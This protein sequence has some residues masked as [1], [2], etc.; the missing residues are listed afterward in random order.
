MRDSAE[1]IVPPE[2]GQIREVFMG[3]DDPLALAAQALVKLRQ[4][5]LPTYIEPA[6]RPAEIEEYV[7]AHEEPSGAE[8]VV[9][10]HAYRR[11]R[12][13]SGQP[14]Q[15]TET[16][17]ADTRSRVA[18]RMGKSVRPSAKFLV[19]R[20]A[21]GA[22]IPD[23]RV[24]VLQSDTAEIA[25]KHAAFD[26]IFNEYSPR[27]IRFAKEIVDSEAIAQ[28][29]VQEAFTAAWRNINRFECRDE[30][31]LKNWLYTITRNASLN[32][33]RA[34]SSSQ[35]SIDHENWE[36]VS[37]MQAVGGSAPTGDPVRTAEAR[38]SFMERL[39]ILDGLNPRHKKIMALAMQGRFTYQEMAEILDTTVPAI[40]SVL[41][42]AR[43]E[44]AKRLAAREDES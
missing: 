21:A 34:K 36:E 6:V 20:S 31:A 9:D 19:L 32:S 26:S 13:S 42:R 18:D 15:V 24:A 28:E 38:E 5:G 43:I 14:S 41:V 7:P 11:A 27:L 33:M 39:E 17:A 3:I 4:H 8:K 23:K 1:I 10:M 12:I 30:N 29:L 22:S 25:D 16:L 35:F 44:F 40:K 37:G 2:D